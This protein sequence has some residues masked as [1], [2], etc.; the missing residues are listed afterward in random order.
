VEGRGAPRDAPA[1]HCDVGTKLAHKFRPRT[2][3]AGCSGGG[4][5]GGSGWIREAQNNSSLCQVLTLSV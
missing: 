1:D 2:A 4:V 3:A 5:I